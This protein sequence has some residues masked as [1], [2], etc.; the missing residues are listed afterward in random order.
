M[1]IAR[2]VGIAGITLI[3]SA[4]AG[5]SSGTSSAPSTTSAKPTTTTTS[6]SGTT[7]T[8]VPTSVQPYL[9]AVTDLPTGWTV[10]NSQVTPPSSCYSNPLTKV[11]SVAYATDKFTQ[12]GT[13]PEL[14]EELGYYT[15]ATNDF[16]TIKGTLD[17]C[18]T[19]TETVGGTT[20]SGVLGA[21]SFPSYG[22]QSAAYVATITAE[23]TTLNQGFV[24]AQKGNY[25][26]IVA[27][28]DIGTFDQGSLQQFTA[29]ALSK[30]PGAS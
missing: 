28:G 10:D 3:G 2:L 13:T 24:I 16:A 29:Q 8:A 25:L 1:K 23:G 12:G 7:T 11:P 5:C 27:L 19:F 20:A 4:L 14:V 21:M 18:K 30:V 6:L 22:N 26:V 15:S 9:L 17:A